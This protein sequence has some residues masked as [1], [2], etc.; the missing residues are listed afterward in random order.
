MALS[1]DR[2][3]RQLCTVRAVT[4]GSRLVVEVDVVLAAD[5]RLHRAHD[6][7]QSLQHR[8]ESLGRV[9][10]AYVHVD[11]ETSHSP[12]SEHKLV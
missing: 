12:W 3:V 6:V 9:E 5:T 2:R 1:H 10:R 11:Y 7:A 8:L 4:S